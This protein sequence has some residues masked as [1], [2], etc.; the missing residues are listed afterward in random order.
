MAFSVVIV[1]TPEQVVLF[2]R[3]QEERRRMGVRIGGEAGGV[4]RRDEVRARGGTSVY[5]GMG[6]G[7][8]YVS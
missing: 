2:C 4:Q 1:P 8:E 5:E 3:W 7:V 6:V